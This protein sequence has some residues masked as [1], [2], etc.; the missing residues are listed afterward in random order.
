MS[1]C[2][3]R[4]RGPPRGVPSQQHQHPL[5]ASQR[6]PLAGPPGSA[7]SDT[8]GGSLQP[9]SSRGRCSRLITALPR[10]TVPPSP[11]AQSQGCAPMELACWFAAHPICQAQSFLLHSLYQLMP[12]VEAKILSTRK[13]CT[14]RELRIKFYLGTK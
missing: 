10:A 12:T 8:L 3:T 1:P 9:V 2:S 5:G 11:R 6:C 7:E 13:K 4:G 14:T